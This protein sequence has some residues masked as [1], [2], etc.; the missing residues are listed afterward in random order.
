M[1]FE[2]NSVTLRDYNVVYGLGN[3]INGTNVDVCD[4]LNYCLFIPI[5]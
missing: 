1:D 3:N 2:S 4:T 5:N